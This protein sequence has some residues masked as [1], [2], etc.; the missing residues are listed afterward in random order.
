MRRLY[1][2]PPSGRF[3]EYLPILLAYRKLVEKRYVIFELLIL[4]LK[5]QIYLIGQK[6]II[7]EL[8]IP[9]FI[10][11]N[12]LFNYVFILLMILNNFDY[13]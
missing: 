2:N 9:N 10:N 1:C 4:D 7:L 3:R 5:N 12:N 13:Y 8:F 6:F 11:L